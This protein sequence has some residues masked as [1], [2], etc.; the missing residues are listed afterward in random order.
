MEQRQIIEP[1][2]VY[3]LETT[4]YTKQDLIVIFTQA[5]PNQVVMSGLEKLKLEGRL[6]GRAEVSYKPSEGHSN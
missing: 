2:L 3:I 5:T 6:E 1:V 4:R